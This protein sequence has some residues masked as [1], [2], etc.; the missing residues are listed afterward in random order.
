MGTIRLSDWS[1]MKS[2][3][4]VI[5]VSLSLVA[6]VTICLMLLRSDSV[7]VNTSTT[8]SDS[9]ITGTLESS[10]SEYI[11]VRLLAT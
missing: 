9:S 10:I 5:N 4:I 11:L 8:P 1:V 3:V 2:E 6:R 7:R